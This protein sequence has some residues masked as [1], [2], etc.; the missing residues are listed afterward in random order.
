MAGVSCKQKLNVVLISREI[1]G[2]GDILVHRQ[3]FQDIQAQY[4]LPVHF[5]CPKHY[6]PV[7]EG[8]PY[9]E[10]LL[11]SSSVNP[12]EY[13]LSFNT[14]RA[15]C[16]F[17][18]SAG[19]PEK[20]WPRAQIWAGACGVKL[21][22]PRFHFAVE[23]YQLPQNTVLIAPISACTR[24]SLATHQIQSLVHAL[25]ERGLE[26]LCVHSEPIRASVPQ[27]HGLSLT[28][29]LRLI[30][31]APRVVSVDTSAFHAAGGLGRPLV[32]LHSQFQGD[33]IGHYYRQTIFQ[34]PVG[35]MGDLDIVEVAEAVQRL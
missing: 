3:I 15:C 10:K 20:S 34:Q 23:P 27:I 9:V 33:I 18:N 17:E 2:L 6:H 13:R 16:L 21:A 24:K 26:P 11:D 25:E 4:G 32:A 22:N 5:A 29:W 35:R 14:S 8:H 7:V 1:G 19:S 31:S 28:R 30:A 12:H